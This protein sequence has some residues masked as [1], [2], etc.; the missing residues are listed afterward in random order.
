[1]DSPAPLAHDFTGPDRLTFDS[2]TGLRNEHLFRLQLPMEFSRARDGEANGA[3]VAIR[4]DNILAINA[5]HGR[6]GGDEALRAVAY[7][8]ENSRSS[9]GKESH[10]VFKLSGPVFGYYIP[11]CS[12]PEGRAIAEEIRDRVTNSDLY[13]GRLT[14]SLGVVNLYEFFTEEGTREE[15]ALRIEQTAFHRL[16]TAERAGGNTVCDSSDI[17]E[18][19]ISARPVVLIVDPE[20]QSMELLIRALEAAELT[21]KTCADGESAVSFIQ[22]SPPGAII[23]EAMTPQLNGFTVRD[24]MRANALWNAIPFILVSHK[25]TEEFIRKAVEGKILHF[26]KKPLSVAEVVGLVTNLTR[27]KA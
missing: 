20:P 1:M 10:L 8:L 6:S 25:K 15:I 12:A 23:C 18:D 22:A 17:T 13:I 21:V 16:T 24:R 7:I 14:V 19:A 4:L 27:N 2:L 26:L 9:P 5:Q 3:L 11:A